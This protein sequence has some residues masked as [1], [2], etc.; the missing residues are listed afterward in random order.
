MYM[1]SLFLVVYGV[2]YMCRV[3]NSFLVVDVT[4][5]IAF[6]TDLSVKDCHVA[7]RREATA[8]TRTIT[9]NS[10]TTTTTTT[11]TWTADW[12][13]INQSRKEAIKQSIVVWPFSLSTS[14]SLVRLPNGQ[15]VIYATRQPEA[16]RHEQESRH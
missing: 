1:H 6:L 11:A 12:E 13:S 14:L 8:T 3:S 16:S 15:Q 9:T 4:A 5:A 10:T 7:T 2:L